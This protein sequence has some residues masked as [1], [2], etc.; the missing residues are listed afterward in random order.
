MIDKELLE[1][2]ACPEDK[3]PVHLADQ[4]VIDGL[5]E[6]IAQSE[7]ANRGGQK[8]EKQIDGGLVRA[9]GAFLYPIDDGFPIMLIDE[10]IPLT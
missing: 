2:L 6:R 7:L 4:S 1:I 8:V 10:A 9:D 5:N 3:S